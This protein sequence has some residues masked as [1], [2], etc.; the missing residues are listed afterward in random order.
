MSRILIVDDDPR[1]PIMLR[2]LLKIKGHEGISAESGLQALEL[3]KQDAFDLIISDLRMPK[4]NGIEFLREV[5]TLNPSIPVILVTAYASKE[6]TIDSVKLGAFDYLSKPFKV[7]ELMTIIGRALTV[8]KDKTRAMDGYSGN[9][10]AI[11]ECLAVA[12]GF[13]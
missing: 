3:I 1:I 8:D 2:H 5:K 4:M 7:D 12:G 13:A 9:N 6:T 10:L 11:K